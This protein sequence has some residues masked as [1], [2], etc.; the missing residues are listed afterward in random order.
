M[1]YD[2]VL[3]KWHETRLQKIMQENLLAFTGVVGGVLTQKIIDDNKKIVKFIYKGGMPLRILYSQLKKQFSIGVENLID[4]IFSSEFKLSDNDFQLIIKTPH[5]YSTDIDDVKLARISLYNKVYYEIQIINYIILREIR[6]IFN[7]ETQVKYF[8]TYFQENTYQKGLL[9]RDLLSEINRQIGQDKAISP[10]D[11][12]FRDIKNDAF[13][14]ILI[15][16]DSV[17]PPENFDDINGTFINFN[18]NQVDLEDFDNSKNNIILLNGSQNLKNQISYILSIAN[19]HTLKFAYNG[20]KLLDNITKDVYNKGDNGSFYV[21]YNSDIQVGITKFSLSRIKYNF[22][23]YGSTTLN[24][25]IFMNLGA[26]VIDVSIGHYENDKFYEFNIL[27]KSD[28]KHYN[29]YN[30]FDANTYYESYSVKGFLHDLYVMLF[31][32]STDINI[33]NLFQDNYYGLIWNDSKYQKRINRILFLSYM[34]IFDSKIDDIYLK[35]NSD[36]LLKIY[37]KLY[38]IFKKDPVNNTPA[39]NELFQLVLTTDLCNLLKTDLLTDVSRN[40]G[41][42]IDVELDGIITNI[43]N[44]ITNLPI[45]VINYR[46]KPINEIQIYNQLRRISGLNAFIYLIIKMIYF[47]VI[48]VRNN[49]NVT[50]DEK[51]IFNRKFNDFKIRTKYSIGNIIE[52]HTAI[53]KDINS[54]NKTINELNKI[55]VESF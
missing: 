52:I 47:N 8:F 45:T 44:I 53:I 41:G 2:N 21:S 19:L 31:K 36:Q 37:K 48:T 17:Y 11:Y 49:M 28:Y 3:K 7:D 30:E 42:A 26:E 50:D 54:E 25:N 39:D 24:Q 9:L 20:D 4:K 16:K 1:I 33:I 51:I 34:E 46:N 40:Y 5:I 43:T 27:D 22:R 15:N 14:T 38:Y 12:T 18:T 55:N 35:K 13:D 6:N 23:I 10:L 29:I 32:Q